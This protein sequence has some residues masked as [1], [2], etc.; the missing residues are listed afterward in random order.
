MASGKPGAVQA[1]WTVHFG[2]A[3]DRDCILTW[4]P[5]GMNTETRV[6]GVH[7]SRPGGYTHMTL[8]DGLRHDQGVPGRGVTRM[9]NGRR[10]PETETRIMNKNRG[11]RYARRIDAR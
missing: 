2:C 9:I 6:R 4:K 10:A 3:H 7:S 8:K 1:G 5:P 11:T